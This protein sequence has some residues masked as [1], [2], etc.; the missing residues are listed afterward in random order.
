[1]NT[2]FHF[3]DAKKIKKKRLTKL[4]GKEYKSL[5]MKN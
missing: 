4:V 3:I 1:L 5:Q 2:P